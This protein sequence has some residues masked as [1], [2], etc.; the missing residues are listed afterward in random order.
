MIKISLEKIEQVK[1]LDFNAR[2]SKIKRSKEEFMFK[3]RTSYAADSSSA[4]ELEAKNITDKIKNYQVFKLEQR[5][6]SNG[7]HYIGSIKDIDKYI[8][9]NKTS[10]DTDVKNAV[11]VLTYLLG[12]YVNG[13]NKHLTINANNVAAMVDVIDF[14]N[15][16]NLI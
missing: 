12:E 4:N 13:G 5:A 2:A 15:A 8:S 1:N 9:D 3:L 6:L 10:S 16:N 11:D 14:L 7:Y